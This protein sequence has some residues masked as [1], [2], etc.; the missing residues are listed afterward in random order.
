[1]SGFQSASSQPEP[2]TGG[3]GPSQQLRVILVGSCPLDR[4]LRREPDIELV[5][6]QTPLRAIGELS[7]PIDPDSLASTVIVLA[8]HCLPD[9]H[10]ATFAGAVRR[11]DDQ[12]RILAIASDPLATLPA[13]FQGAIQPSA[14]LDAF[15]AAISPTRPTARP[16]AKS[17]APE[18]A[19]PEPTI[20][21]HPAAKPASDA[22]S[23]AHPVESG[24]ARPRHTELPDDAKLV[25]AILSGHPIQ[26]AC[27]QQL[28]H[29]THNP[30]LRFEPAT[31]SQP[32]SHAV[33][34][35]H[36]GFTLGYLIDPSK[37]C[38][39]Q[40]LKI[41]ALWLAHWL[42]LAEQQRQL[43]EAA[44]TDSLTGAWNRRYFDRYLG[45]CL[46]KAVRNRQPVTILLFDVD[47]FKR[48]NDQ[49]GHAVGDEILKA[50]VLL[51]K[52]CIRPDDRVCRI[53]GDEFAVVFY[54]PDGPRETGSNQPTSIFDIA[55]RFQQKV[56]TEE[57]RA[58][59]CSPGPLAI[60]GGLAT[61]PWDG[62]TPPELLAAADRLLIESKDAGKNAIR[63]GSGVLC[64]DD[65]PHL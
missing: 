23:D 44:F 26:Q 46:R 53:G 20:V 38:P 10:A 11:L 29:R 6:A 24:S 9:E 49:H 59:G 31:D 62:R 64:C 37:Q 21:E 50:T 34:V 32:G 27:L 33:A 2:S 58:L 17:Q 4:V 12:A 39:P 45:T 25:R 3:E 51:L 41:E 1:M 63:Y 40:Q 18:P 47:D 56:Q 28:R 5:R 52:T 19:V 55:R 57:F 22:R 42:A 54:E 14:G 60:S 15:R 48:F 61:F 35:S 7:Q 13:E 16:S 30:E 65:K 43:R 36:R 8:E